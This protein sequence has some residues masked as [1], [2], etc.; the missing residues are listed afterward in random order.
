MGVLNVTPDSF[1]D[2]G[3]HTSVEQAVE[4]GCRMAEEGAQIIDVGGESTRPGAAP[5]PLEE[6]LRRTIPVIEALSRYCSAC[7]SIDTRKAAVA[8][9]AWRAGAVMIND[10][11][12]M[13]HDP[14]MADVVLETG[15]AVC[16]MHMRGTPE[17]MQQHPTYDDVVREVRD[18]L[19]ERS[20]YAPS[21][22]IGH[23]RIILDP[24]IG[25]GK[26]LQHN[27]ELLR[28]LDVLA[29]LG[30]PVLV[31]TSRKSMLGMLLNGAPPNDRLEGTAA[32]AVW[33]IQQGAAMLRVH[34]VAPLVRFARTADA[35]KAGLAFSAC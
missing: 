19:A 31:G 17:T 15:A 26:T 34:D 7:I 32:T 25:F 35:V 13:T 18:Y 4:H 6:E 24:G 21:L 11:S 28:H 10:V 23:E 33:A 12:A 27:L 14:G 5:V 8:R 16:L 9:K 20:R 30:F 1:S 22:G 2:G 3:L 29:A